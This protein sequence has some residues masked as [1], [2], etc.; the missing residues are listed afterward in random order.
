MERKTENGSSF[1]VDPL[2]DMFVLY[3][4]GAPESNDILLDFINAVLN[5]AGFDPVVSVEVMNPFNLRTFVNDK[6]SILDVKAKD[7][8]GRIFDIEVQSVVDEV[9]INR[10]LYYWARNYAAQMTDGEMYSELKPVI[11]INLLKHKLF[12]SVEKLH[13]VFLAFEKDHKEL[14]LTDHF[15]VH[16]IE[17]EKFFQRDSTGK[18][19][20]ALLQDWLEFFKKEGQEDDA[21][22]T[23]VSENEIIKKAH[24][25]YKS[26]TRSDELR[27]VYEAREKYKRD[28]A[29]RLHLAEK[30][31]IEQ[32]IDKGKQEG[33]QEDA[34][35][36]LE[37]Q[38][39]VDLIQRVTGLSEEEIEGLRD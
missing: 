38:L 22:K 18:T 34:R 39:P 35:R 11:C 13:T 12:D 32:G 10:S 21:M 1:Y 14:P 2:S 28:E 24:D 27:E 15:Q 33:K 36:M 31:G 6:L 17:L 26:F 5:D 9:F 37:E 7:Q 25:R 19:H 20:R 3:L 16:Y 23:L 30:R 29:T 8:N 4:F